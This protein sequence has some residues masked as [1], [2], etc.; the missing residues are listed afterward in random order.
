LLLAT[1]T[2][3]AIIVIHGLGHGWAELSETGYWVEKAVIFVIMAAVFAVV[4]SI[5]RSGGKP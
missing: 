5:R 4:D 1:A 2:V 3:L